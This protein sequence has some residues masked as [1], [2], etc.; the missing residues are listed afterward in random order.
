MEA[1]P[2]PAN[3]FDTILIRSCNLPLFNHLLKETLTLETC[4]RLWFSVRIM[5]PSERN[6]SGH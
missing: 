6:E 2:P 4:S 1:P 5:I 3:A